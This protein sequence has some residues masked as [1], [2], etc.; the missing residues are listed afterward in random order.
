MDIDEPKDII[1]TYTKKTT[2]P[3][4]DSFPNFD[5]SEEKIE[6]DNLNN[7]N[8]INNS[9]NDPD[10]IDNDSIFFLGNKRHRS[11]HT[12]N[13][14]NYSNQNF[15]SPKP[16]INPININD[17][18]NNINIT[19]GINNSQ[20]IQINNDITDN[21]RLD[22]LR[23]KL[24]KKAFNNVKSIIEDKI[25]KKLFINLDAFAFGTNFRQN[26][27]VLSL[28]ICDILCIN[29]KNKK[30]LE[31]IQY[32]NI[33]DE[34][35]ADFLLT[36]SYKFIYQQY[37]NNNKTFLI[38]GKMVVLEEF[39][40]LDDEIEKMDN[41]LEEIEINESGKKIIKKV[42]KYTVKQIKT[43]RKISIDYFNS[44]K[45]GNFDERKSNKKK[46]F[47]ITKSI[48]KYENYIKNNKK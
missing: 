18:N 20:L 32:D 10:K 6:K 28:T 36:R 11:N 45:T 5:Y 24:N 14:I 31:E 27:A 13:I 41:E 12:E 7:I 40:T 48:P 8:M 3:T 9:M 37:I 30:I 26:R 35:I 21:L 23:K 17:F 46:P 43:F 29:T 44:L 25:N 15:G 42:K 34:K 1:T 33:E 4:D 19:N 47:L 39:Q 2:K 16:K 22:N 38:D